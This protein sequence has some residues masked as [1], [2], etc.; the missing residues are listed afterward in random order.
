MSGLELRR[1][2]CFFSTNNSN[3]MNAIITFEINILNYKLTNDAQY[4]VARMSLKREREKK[5]ICMNASATVIS[6]TAVEMSFLHLLSHSEG[7]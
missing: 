5:S 4:I 3:H 7:F 6:G 2:P 1:A